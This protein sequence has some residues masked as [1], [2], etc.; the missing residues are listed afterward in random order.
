MGG[1][2]GALVRIGAVVI[3]LVKRTK[4][5]YREIRNG[6]YPCFI[7]GLTFIGVVIIIAFYLPIWFGFKW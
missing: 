5:P 3:W 7:V 1:G 6:N 2:H 4:T